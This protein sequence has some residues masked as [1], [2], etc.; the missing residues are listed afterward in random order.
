MIRHR[1]VPAFKLAAG[2]ESHRALVMQAIARYTVIASAWM[3]NS[4]MAN[5][6]ALL[7]HTP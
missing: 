3:R 6:S 5:S 2:G 1:A 4:Q 7:A